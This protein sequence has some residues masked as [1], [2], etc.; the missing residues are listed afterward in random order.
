[1]LFVMVF[2]IPCESGSDS[3]F[4]TAFEIQYVSVSAMRYV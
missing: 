3:P 1:M 4:E 2:E